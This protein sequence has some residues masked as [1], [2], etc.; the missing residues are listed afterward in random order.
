MVRV[1]VLSFL[2][3][4]LTPVRT[5]FS[6]ENK[7]FPTQLL[8]DYT[9]LRNLG[10]IVDSLNRGFQNATSRPRYF[11]ADQAIGH[12]VVLHGVEARA[13]K[14]D[15]DRNIGLEE[16]RKKYPSCS[17]IENLLVLKE[18]HHKDIY[19]NAHVLFSN[20]EMGDVYERKIYTHDTTIYDKNLKGSWIAELRDDRPP[21]LEA[22]YF[23]EGFGSTCIPDKYASMIYYVDCVIDKNS[24][25][26]VE[27]PA[28]SYRVAKI[29]AD[30][31]F[32]KKAPALFKLTRFLHD[33]AG[34]PERRLY[35]DEGEYIDDYNEWWYVTA[36]SVI[37][38]Q[39]RNSALLKELISAAVDEA[40][41]LSMPNQLL[42][43][44]AE[45]SETKER[46][47]RLLRIR[48]VTGFCSR[49]SEPAK[50]TQKI[51]ILAAQTGHWDIFIRAHMDVLNNRFESI[52]YSGFNYFSRKTHVE[53]LERIHLNVP[54]LLLGTA[55]R[56]E[57]CKGHYFGSISEMGRALSESERKDE[58]EMY[59]AEA[60]SDTGL[61]KFNRVIMCFLY[62][63]YVYC[64]NDYKRKKQDIKEYN[65]LVKTLPPY[66]AQRLAVKSSE[67]YPL[68]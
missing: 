3:V 8:Y 65:K 17:I 59:M 29:E 35:Y 6:D 14:Q 5:K 31:Q 49:D 11:S 16:F 19:S 30:K 42:E 66:F 4:F 37:Q 44:L 52:A 21:Y 62:K 45:L 38:N 46:M 9:T 1:L 32:S 48:K 68:W 60:I 50:H 61:D 22:Y 23:P 2:L 56:L 47:L 51:A 15:I 40:L 39:L 27:N 41:D 26:L 33:S 67:F 25:V 57:N 64:L 7:R 43:R 54:V 58:I 13:A 36:D 55:F 28:E 10:K 24:R 63:N 53:E 12:Y 20:I 18:M 34:R